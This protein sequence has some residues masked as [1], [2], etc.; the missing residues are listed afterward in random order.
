MTFVSNDQATHRTRLQTA[1]GLRR[2]ET[3]K[4]LTL[5]G[6]GARSGILLELLVLLPL[7]CLLL[8]L[9]LLV[10]VVFQQEQELLGGLCGSRAALGVPL[11]TCTAGSRQHEHS[12]CEPRTRYQTACTKRRATGSPTRL[13]LAARLVT[14]AGLLTFLRK[15][16]VADRSMRIPAHPHWQMRRDSFL[17]HLSRGTAFHGRRRCSMATL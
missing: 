1:W 7:Q 2:V 15:P 8:H 16:L 13:R 5:V 3:C 12:P 14:A 10:H 9:L 11:P 4:T 6:L 17:G